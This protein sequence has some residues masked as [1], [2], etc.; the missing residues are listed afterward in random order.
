[1][2]EPLNLHTAG[3]RARLWQI[4]ADGT[5]HPVGDQMPELPELRRYI[6]GFVEHVGLLVADVELHMFCN[7]N[8][9]RERLPVNHEATRLYHAGG[10]MPSPVVGNVWLWFGELPDEDDDDENDYD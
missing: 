8:G 7:E 6:G 10:G 3:K 2:T 4:A 1:M 9:D 5:Q